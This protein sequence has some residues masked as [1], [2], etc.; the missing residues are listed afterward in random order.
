MTV[1][2]SADSGGTYQV[3]CSG[4]IGKALKQIQQRANAEGR[5]KQV[6]LAI[7]RVWQRLLRDPVSFGEPLYRLPALRMQIRQGAVRPLLVN[8]A[9]CEDR[10]LVFIRGVK[11]L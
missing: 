5:G 11:M 1:L 4:V 2:P 9:V 3:H 8:F 10:P 6:L 7:R